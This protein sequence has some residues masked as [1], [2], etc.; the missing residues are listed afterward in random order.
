M[1][2]TA[3][4]AHC[5][6]KSGPCTGLQCMGFAMSLG[7]SCSQCRNSVRIHALCLCSDRLYCEDPP[8]PIRDSWAV[9]S[10]RTDSRAFDTARITS[11]SSRVSGPLQLSPEPRG[12]P[13][14]SGFQPIWCPHVQR[15][16]HSA[17]GSVVTLP[18][19]VDRSAHRMCRTRPFSWKSVW[20]E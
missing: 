8:V 6:L 17:S 5:T 15:R 7:R 16:R 20:I 9:A 13:G 3:L 4:L 10:V 18:D 12:E 11:R 2:R 14:S 1:W 19:L